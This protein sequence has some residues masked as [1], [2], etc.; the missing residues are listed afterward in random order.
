MVPDAERYHPRSIAHQCIC[1]ETCAPHDRYLETAN[2]V[3]EN[4][5]SGQTVPSDTAGRIGEPLAYAVPVER[6]CRTRVFAFTLV[7]VLESGHQ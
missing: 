7:H 5:A 6:E 1:S 2:A 3:G 4:R